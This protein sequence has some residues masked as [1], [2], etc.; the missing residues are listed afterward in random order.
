MLL[1]QGEVL[2]P[3]GRTVTNQGWTVTVEARAKCD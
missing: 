1:S 3:L 2:Q